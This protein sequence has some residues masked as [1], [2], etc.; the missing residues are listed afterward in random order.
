MR[1]VVKIQGVYNEEFYKIYTKHKNCMY[2]MYKLYSVGESHSYLWFML[3]NENDELVG[4]CSIQNKSKCIVRTFELHDVC[5]VEKFRGNNF[6]LL[7]IVN[8][9]YYLDTLYHTYNYIIKAHDDNYPAIKTY[10]KIAGNPVYKNGFAFFENIN[11][12]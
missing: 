6:A 9:L 11:S 7:M 1:L 10:T 5:I 2:A 12:F 4:E 8:V 3:V